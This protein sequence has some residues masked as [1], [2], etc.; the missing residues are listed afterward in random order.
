MARNRCPNCKKR[1]PRK[2]ERCPRCGTEVESR[3]PK[4]YER[5]SVTLCV[6]A[7]LAGIG[8]GFIHVIVSVEGPFG[9][10]FD[11]APRQH[12]G[13]R[14]MVVDAGKI[15]AL[16]YVAARLKYPLGC[17]VLRRLEYLPSSPTFETRM[18]Y[19][20]REAMD[21]WYAEFEVATGR[22]PCPWQDRLQE[23]PQASETD[24]QGAAACNR[25]AVTYARQGKYADA[26]SELATAT[27][28][29]PVCAEAYYN[30]ALVYLALGNLGQAA[31]DLGQVVQIRPDSV[32]AYVERGLIHV[33]SERYDEAVADFSQAVEIEPTCAEAY[34]RRSM[35]RYAKGE[36]NAALQDVKKLRSLGVPVPSGF[37]HAL[38]GGPLLDESTKDP[39][40]RSRRRR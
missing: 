24:P 25:R 1:V 4:W 40:F 39:P 22:A 8:F 2:A 12:F 15:G 21:R 32:E 19:E 14:E 38:Q 13:Y 37:L 23:P 27:R 3:P 31:S 5:T 10:P 9:L 35:V 16:P 20:L 36:Q 7:V 18:V 30:R 11:L 26:L 29:D 33:T 28:K 34:L 17:E 6:A